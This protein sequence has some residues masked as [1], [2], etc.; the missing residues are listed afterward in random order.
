MGFEILPWV[1]GNEDRFETFILTSNEKW[2]PRCYL[3]GDEF[4]SD[5]TQGIHDVLVTSQDDK[6]FKEALQDK[7][8]EAMQDK[9]QDTLQDGQFNELSELD[10][11]S[12]EAQLTP[13]DGNNTSLSSAS[14][15]L[16]Y[17]DNQED[18]ISTN[19]TVVADTITRAVVPSGMVIPVPITWPEKDPYYF[20]PSDENIT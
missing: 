17:P 7:P 9:F 14:Q 15:D 2:M 8:P 6:E 13:D 19:E 16:D 3:E 18:H 20:D 12:I 10:N 11:L 1:K 5:R 4:I